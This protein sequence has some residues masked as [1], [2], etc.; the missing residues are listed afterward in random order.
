M[1]LSF[2]RERDA[3]YSPYRARAGSDNSGTTRYLNTFQASGSD[4]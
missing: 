1:Q 3:P 4:F 2:D